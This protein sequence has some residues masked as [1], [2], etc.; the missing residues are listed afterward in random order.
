MSLKQA[1][2]NISNIDNINANDLNL[3]Q[4]LIKTD[5]WSSTQRSHALKIATK[6]HTNISKQDIKA[7]TTSKKTKRAVLRGDRFYLFGDFEKTEKNKILRIPGR[8]INKDGYNVPHNR[9]SI[10][11]LEEMRFVFS[12]NVIGIEKPIQKQDGKPIFPEGCMPHEYQWE[13]WKIIEK[14]GGRCLLADQPRLGKTIQAMIYMANHPDLRPA[15][16]I[17]PSS[18]KIQWQREINKWLPNERCWVIHGRTGIV[19]KEGIAIIN[20]DILYDHY[21]EIEE[22]NFKIII[23]DEC[24]RVKNI[25]AK[26]TRAFK[27]IAKTVPHIIGISGTPATNRPREFY[28]ILNVIAPDMFNNNQQ[29]LDR[30][31]NATHDP[32]GKGSSNIEELHEILKNSIM[33]RRTRSEVWKDIP[34]KQRII[35]PI[36]IDNRSEYCQAE[37]DLIAYLREFKG[38]RAAQ[39]AIRSKAFAKFNILKEIAARGKLKQAL[40]WIE[41]FTEQEKLVTFC[42][43]RKMVEDIHEHFQK[44]SVKLYGGMSNKAKDMS[45]SR[46]TKDPNITLFIGNL[47]AANLGLPLHVAD[48]TF[49]LEYGWVPADHEQAEDRVINKEKLHVP[50]TAYYMTAINTIEETIAEIIDS[51]TKVLSRLLDGKEAEEEGLL[52]YLIDKYSNM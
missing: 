26:R 42:I 7:T 36:E 49:T 16:I 9:Y 41:D 44:T 12:Q 48:A 38:D 6:Y 22:N 32:T 24:H 21:C 39:N 47:T 29:F 11:V 18:I 28:T 31:C 51:K 52:T 25:E 3:I 37:Q 19:P 15:L 40:E 30:Y 17:V 4:T 43:H 8:I 50:I 27:Y 35:I 13:G 2:E 20:Y 14:F 33:I 45:V 46:F 5:I 1:L 10:N 23:T 34:E